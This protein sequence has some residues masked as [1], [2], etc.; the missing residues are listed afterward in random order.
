MFD[1]IVIKVNE[2]ETCTV[3]PVKF[4]VR[5]N[6]LDQMYEWIDCQ[7]IDATT[8]IIEGIK[9]TCWVDDEGILNGKLPTIAIPPYGQILY[10]NVLLTLID[11]AGDIRPFTGEEFDKIYNALTGE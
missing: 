6:Q 3:Q 10:G 5:R 1:G 4:N 9:V 2:D 8:A 7:C 11:Q